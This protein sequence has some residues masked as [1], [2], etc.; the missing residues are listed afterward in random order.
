MVFTTPDQDHPLQGHDTAFSEGASDRRSDIGK[1]VV[2]S[3]LDR[4]FGIKAS[5]NCDP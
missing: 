5:P 4:L 2:D 1:K 3:R